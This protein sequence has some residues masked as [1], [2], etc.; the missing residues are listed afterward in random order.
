M[1]K[2]FIYLRVSTDD[3]GQDPELQLKDCLNLVGDLEYE[4]FQEKVSA[5]RVKDRPIFDTMVKRSISEKV[6]VIVVWDLDRL[7]RN[8]LKMVSF[9]KEMSKANIKVKSTRQKWL[10]NLHQI[11][12]PWNEIVFD[13]V[14][15]II[16]WMAEEESLKKSERVKLAVTTKHG[17]TVSKNGNKWG[18][19][20][21]SQYTKAKIRELRAT[22]L[23]YRA[24]AEEMNIKKSTVAKYS[25]E[26]KN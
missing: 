23:S 25:K 22:D 24:I 10:E 4:V 14:I 6:G 11:P 9:V 7:Y 17:R 1:S 3:K 2:A 26:V 18:R 20:G 19:P 8:R 12:Y 16:G 13:L 21:V 15:N 5:W